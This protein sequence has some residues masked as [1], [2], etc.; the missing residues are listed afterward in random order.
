MTVRSIF[1]VMTL[2]AGAIPAL[3]NA[4]SPPSADQFYR[5]ALAHTRELR[6][7]AYATYD[8]VMDGLD[9]SVTGGNHLT[10]SLKLMG[11]TRPSSM[12]VAYRTLD[13]RIALEQGVTR[14]SSA[15]RRS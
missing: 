10:C 13:D 11:R 3:A 12:A 15:T 2:I 8:A 6:E 14:S 9:C 4:Q 1:A 5:Q 7:P